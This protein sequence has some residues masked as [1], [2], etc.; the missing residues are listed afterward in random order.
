MTEYYANKLIQ[1]YDLHIMSGW[2]YNQVKEHYGFGKATNDHIRATF[3]RFVK[4]GASLQDVKDYLD[5][6]YLQSAKALEYHVRFVGEHNRQISAQRLAEE[7]QIFDV[8]WLK[9]MLN[10]LTITAPG[11]LY[12]TDTHGMDCLTIKI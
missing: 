6:N 12:Y 1:A 4:I 7:L 2:N 5:R 3:H 9:C 11:L 8:D 10:G